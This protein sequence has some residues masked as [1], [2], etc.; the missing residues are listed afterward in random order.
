MTKK[1]WQ[2]EQRLFRKLEREGKEA[3]KRNAKNGT[4]RAAAA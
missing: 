1:R 3:L 4:T 2:Q